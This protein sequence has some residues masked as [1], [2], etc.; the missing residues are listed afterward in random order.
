MSEKLEPPTGR[1]SASQQTQSYWDRF[2]IIDDCESDEADESEDDD[3]DMKELESRALDQYQNADIDNDVINDKI[4]DIESDEDN[5]Q[6]G[7]YIMQ[8]QQQR[9]N[10]LAGKVPG[11]SLGGLQGASYG[12]AKAGE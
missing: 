2:E 10:P 1:S 3:V 9:T 4:E 12:A 7:Q 11:L 5:Q 6:I 8:E